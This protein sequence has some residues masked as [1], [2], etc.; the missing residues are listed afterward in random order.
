MDCDALD[1]SRIRATLAGAATLDLVCRARVGASELPVRMAVA[2]DSITRGFGASC[3]CNLGFQCLLECGFGGVEQ[4]QHS[5]F[6]GSSSQVFALLDRYRVFNPAIAAN[7]GAAESGAR[8]RGGSDSFQIQ[9][10][11]ILAQSPNP[12]LVV[13]LLGGNDICSRDCATPGACASPLFSDTEWRDAIGLGLAPLAASLPEGATVYLG[14]VPRVQDLYAAGLA[15]Q[16][17][18]NDVD[19]ELVWSAAEIC[20]IV[21]DETDNNEE[22]QAF[23][24]AAIAER[25][26]RYNEILRDEAVAYDSNANGLNPRGIRVVAEYTDESTPSVGTLV[27]GRDEINGSDCFHPSLAGQN[28]LAELLWERS[29]VR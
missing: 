1:E 22:T 23:R 20:R 10:G 8:M 19:C 6:N 2:G 17:L 4:P 28:A 12:D 13:V 27:F 18:E 7:S 21:T 14:S 15:K 16:D 3:T 5:W 9:A 29:P 24:L 26:R 25:Q 11:R